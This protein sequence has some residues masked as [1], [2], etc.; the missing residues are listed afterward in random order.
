MVY[1]RARLTLI[2]IITFFG[3]V[4][5]G[6]CQ[7]SQS[8]LYQPQDN[9]TRFFL[10]R[11]EKRPM[12]S[13]R[14]DDGEGLRYLLKN[15]PESERLLNDYQKNIP[16]PT[17]LTVTSTTGF[18]IVL[19]GFLAAP[20]LADSP[21][22]ARNIRAAFLGTGLILALGSYAYNQRR[23]SKNEEILK[24]AIDLF[25]ES[26]PVDKKIQMGFEFDPMGKQGQI[27]TEVRL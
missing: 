18:A 11:G 3:F 19:G 20:S 25:N 27:I 13:G 10:Y 9:C 14:R 21:T 8:S 17:W 23:R 5:V 26:M 24:R 6:L 12:D 1:L 15:N 2:A 4:P 7:M 22:K 16:F